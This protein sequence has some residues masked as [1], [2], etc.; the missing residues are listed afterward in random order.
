M[1]IKES[2]LTVV[3]SI[4]DSDFVRAVTSAGASRKLSVS[5]LAKHIV[6]TYTGSTIAGS[7]QSVKS[8]VDALK[9][10]QETRSMEHV[11]RIGILTDKNIDN[12][13]AN[14]VYGTWWLNHG[15]NEVTGTKPASSGQGLLICKQQS[16]TIYRQVYIGISGN[17]FKC[18]YHNGSSWTAWADTPIRDELDALKSAHISV[19]SLGTGTAPKDFVKSCLENDTL[20]YNTTFV[21]KFAAGYNYWGVGL[22]YQVSGQTYG[23]AIVGRPNYI[24]K[25]NCSADTWTETAI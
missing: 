6:E 5:N 3:N 7:A 23:S 25:V 10:E 22:F 12:F 24:C 15:D 16:A 21:A 1:A 14:K 11:G 8:A 19:P 9:S 17:E 18:R 13:A 20:P 4:G 2:L